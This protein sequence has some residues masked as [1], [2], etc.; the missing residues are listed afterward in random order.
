LAQLQR[1][2]SN[3]NK[4]AGGESLLDE[5][6]AFFVVMFKK[7]NSNL[8]PGLSIHAFAEFITDLFVYQSPEEHDAFNVSTT[9]LLN[10]SNYTVVVV[11][12][13]M[14][15]SQDPTTLTHYI[16]AAALYMYD[17]KHG[18]YVAPLRT[19][20]TGNPSVCTLS[21]RFYVDQSNSGLLQWN[22]S[23]FRGFGLASFLLSTIQVLGQ[24]R[25]KPTPTTHILTTIIQCD[26]VDHEDSLRHHL[27]LQSRLEMG[28]A[29]VMY[30]Q[31]AVIVVSPT[32]LS[33]PSLRENST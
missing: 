12:A 6:P 2:S 7:F 28:S 25:Y 20:D 22:P 14:F 27:Y 31:T 30:V 13:P 29:Y 17:N 21:E 32:R 24:L 1:F 18:N 8:P 5:E 3:C 16:I 23:S 33:A 9:S 26:E 19:M 11:I 15:S 10:N 4:R